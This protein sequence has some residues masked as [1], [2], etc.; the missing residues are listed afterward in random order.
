M[1]TFEESTCNYITS[2]QLDIYIESNLLFVHKRYQLPLGTHGV[3]YLKIT[4]K[5]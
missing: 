2:S 1:D 3:Q 5:R 4:G